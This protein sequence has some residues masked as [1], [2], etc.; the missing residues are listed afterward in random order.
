MFR[1]LMKWLTVASVALVL[2]G[3]GF[4]PLYGMHEGGGR[5][6]T[7]LGQIKVLEI[8]SGR[9]GHDVYNALIDNLSPSGEPG[10]PDYEL[11]VRLTE[12]REGVA[13]ERDASITRYNFQL[14]AS[15]RLVDIRSGNVIYEGRSRSIAAYNVVESQFA[16]LSARRDA[17]ERA[18]T[19]LSE[20]I[21]L[22][23]AIFFDRQL[24]TGPSS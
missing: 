12:D 19:E 5:T 2:G 18:A 4:T 1:A 6:N 9:T 20:D 14:N 10:E 23:L 3:C 13:I 24:N 22:R 17:E 8:D 16:T 11:R 15:F 21:K 7:E